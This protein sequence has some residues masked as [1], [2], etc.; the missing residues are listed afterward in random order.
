METDDRFYSNPIP[1]KSSIIDSNRFDDEQNPPVS[2]EEMDF[3]RP[4]FAHHHRSESAEKYFSW[5]E[6]TQRKL[7]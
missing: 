5:A 3:E 1:D 7:Q 2:D 4:P 6:K